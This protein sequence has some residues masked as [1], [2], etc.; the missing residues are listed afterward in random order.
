MDLT[1]SA[2][3]PTF[4]V[5][6]LR[7]SHGTKSG[8]R[9]PRRWRRIRLFQ[10]RK[11]LVFLSLRCHRLFLGSQTRSL[12]TRGSHWACRSSGLSGSSQYFETLRCDHCLL[13]KSIAS[14]ILS[15]SRTPFIPLIAI[16]SSQHSCITITF[17]P[18]VHQLYCYATTITTAIKNATI[19]TNRCMCLREANPD[20]IHATIEAIAHT[21]PHS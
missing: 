18:S 7:Q 13:T 17:S 12:T 15:H 11:W 14:M 21:Q 3:V 5:P 9:W 1:Q 10:L 2:V 19:C 8:L 16:I 4:L 6:R 20:N